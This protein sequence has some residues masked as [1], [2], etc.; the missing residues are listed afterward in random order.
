MGDTTQKQRKNQAKKGYWISNQVLDNEGFKEL[1]SAIRNHWSVEV[2]HQ[3]RDVQMGEDAMKI[4]NKD[5]AI[6]VAS[7]LTLA[8]NLVE[9][10]GGSIAVLRK[11]LSKN[12]KLIPAIFK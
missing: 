3:I 7:F 10:Q 4:S 5:E 8:T 2:H 9:K 12:W 11:K 1:V 6:V